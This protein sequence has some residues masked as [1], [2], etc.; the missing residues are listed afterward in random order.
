M[1]RPT[2]GLIILVIAFLS[3]RWRRQSQVP[4]ALPLA[5]VALV[6]FQGLLG[7]WTVTLLLK[8]LIVTAHLA[9]G[10]TTLSMLWWLWMSLRRGADTG[11]LG[12]SAQCAARCCAAPRDCDVFAPL[13]W[14]R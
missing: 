10:L 3:L 13:P 6:I 1:A 8:P 4:I 12:A 2:L 7:M 11:R 9:F 5:L 14:W